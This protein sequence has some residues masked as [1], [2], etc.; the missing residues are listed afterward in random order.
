MLDNVARVWVL[1]VGAQGGLAAVEVAEVVDGQGRVVV[2]GVAA[3]ADVGGAL[4]GTRGRLDGHGRAVHVVLLCTGLL[5]GPGPGV[6]VGAGGDVL[7][8]VHVVGTGT[9]TVLGRAAA[10]NGEDDAPPG[11]LRGLHV[12]GQ[13]NLTG[14]ASVD[15][16]AL[17]AHRNVLAGGVLIADATG[18]VEGA[19]G[20]TD[21]AR[22]VGSR[23]TQRAVGERVGR[24]RSRGRQDHV[25]RGCGSPNRQHSGD[26][27]G[28][29]R[30]GVKTGLCEE[31]EKPKLGITEEVKSS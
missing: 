17:E 28:K 29:R 21:L 30:H 11:G 16:G 27:V 5:G 7:G 31:G 9:G 12:G 2:E 24:V 13:G 4:L 14:A 19:G 20:A 18:G 15:G 6:A 3:G 8:D 22:V 26:V 10:L 25:G 23:R 1:G